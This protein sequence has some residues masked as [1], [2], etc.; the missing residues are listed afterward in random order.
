MKPLKTNP[1]APFLKKGQ[2]NNLC[3][4]YDLNK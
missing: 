4:K 2:I 3:K 1:V